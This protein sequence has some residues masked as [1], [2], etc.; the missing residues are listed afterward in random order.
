MCRFPSTGMPPDD[1]YNEKSLVA[2]WREMEEIDE[3]ILLAKKREEEL[4]PVSGLPFDS[5]RKGVMKTRKKIKS[6]SGGA[7]SRLLLRVAAELSR[8]GAWKKAVQR[9]VEAEEAFWG[10]TCQ[11]CGARYD[12]DARVFCD[13]CVCGI[14]GDAK[15]HCRGC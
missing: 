4:S 10:E 13:D 5:Q 2:L 1:Y 8:L 12:D 11:T 15:K 3:C 6:K 9:A 14:C 7:A